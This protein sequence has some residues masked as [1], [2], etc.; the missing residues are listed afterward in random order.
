[1][2]AFTAPFQGERCFCFVPLARCVQPRK[3]L[4]ILGREV[5]LAPS[6]CVAGENS[7]KTRCW[8]TGRPA[9]GGKKQ[10]H[11]SAL[12]KITKTNTTNYKGGNHGTDTAEKRKTGWKNFCLFLSPTLPSPPPTKKTSNQQN[13]CQKVLSFFFRASNMASGPGRGG[14]HSHPHGR[15]S[16]VLR[17]A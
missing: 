6:H 17:D 1:M 4:L 12:L 5:S 11:I 16:A 10:R 2:L 15:T 13:A 3:H 9:E 14:A 8:C 7:S